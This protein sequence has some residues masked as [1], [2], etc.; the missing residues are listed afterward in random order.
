MNLF[1]HLESGRAFP[2]RRVLL[3]GLHGIGTSTFAAGLPSPVFV[4]ANDSIAHINCQRFPVAKSF[5][6]FMQ[7]LRELY[8]KPHDYRTVVLDPLEAIEQLI[9]QE[10]CHERGV[11]H[12]WQLPNAAIYLLAHWRRLLRRLELL[13]GDIDLHIVLIGHAR[14]SWLQVAHSDG[15]ATPQQTSTRRYGPALSRRVSALL[16]GW[17]DEVLFATHVL[18]Q[19]LSDAGAGGPAAAVPSKAIQAADGLPDDPRVL[20]TIP[21]LS[22]AAKNHLNLPPRLPLRPAAWVPYLHRA[23]APSQ[24][25]PANLN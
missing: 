3:Y 25:A 14:D 4:P 17:C 16:Q 1:K 6:E 12:L 11:K 7:S 5:A 2:P 21:S 24:M 20:Q 10:V 13:R 22:H 18:P 15:S 19:R 23:P 9:N 8:I